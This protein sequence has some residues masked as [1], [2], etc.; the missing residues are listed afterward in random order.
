MTL[1]VMV[2]AIKQGKIEKI[3]L[4]CFLIID[5]M[6]FYSDKMILIIQNTQEK[7]FRQIRD[8]DLQNRSVSRCHC[9]LVGHALWSG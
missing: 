2:A 6:L 4:L 9:L 8:D 1:T 7:R 5:S 3:D